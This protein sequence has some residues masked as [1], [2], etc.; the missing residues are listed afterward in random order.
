MS[1]RAYNKTNGR[2]RL[3]KQSNDHHPVPINTRPKGIS[4]LGRGRTMDNHLF[5]TPHF[6]SKTTWDDIRRSHLRLFAV[7]RSYK[8]SL[9]QRPTRLT[10][11]ST[12]F[13]ILFEYSLQPSI[14][15]TFS[16]TLVA[17]QE[18]TCLSNMSVES[19][20]L[21]ENGMQQVTFLKTPIM[22]TYVRLFSVFLFF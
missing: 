5:A 4:L 1:Q 8:N 10:K 9:R 20:T 17:P 11:P 22:A 12:I 2:N 13:C 21:L 7:S 18:V 16:L 3:S 15:A 19:I 6:W 14:K